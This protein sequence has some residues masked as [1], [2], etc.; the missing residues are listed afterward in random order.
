MI[1]VESAA[2]A[3][4]SFVVAGHVAVIREFEMANRTNPGLLDNLA[5]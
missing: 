5:M 1:A 3:F 2:N 4:R